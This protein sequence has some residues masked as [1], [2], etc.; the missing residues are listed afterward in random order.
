MSGQ[1]Y[2][3]RLRAALRLAE[4]AHRE[5]RRKGSADVPYIVHPV[6]VAAALA[7]AGADEDLVC[8]GYLHDVVEDSATTIETIAAGFGARVAELVLA[9][10]EEKRDA[11]GADIPWEV[12]K[13]R[14]L[15]H[16]VGMDD[17]DVFA[18]KAADLLVN[19][20]D[21]AV[22]H[23]VVGDRI[24]ERFRRGRDAQLAYYRAA[25]EAVLPQVALPALAAGL[26]GAVARLD[27]LAADAPRA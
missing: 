25:A 11:T 12:R 27:A 3:A 4:R 16:L 7:A 17:P 20:T 22:D 18:L 24:W 13:D 2:S 19:L 26:R 14:Q 6:A 9:V 5:Q 21:I 10:T 8:A 15:A 1:L 23:D